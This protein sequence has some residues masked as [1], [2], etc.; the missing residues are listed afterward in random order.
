MKRRRVVVLSVLVAVLGVT[1]TGFAALGWD[2]DELG[3][4]R[5]G[6]PPALAPGELRVVNLN[7]FRLGQ[8]ERVP[9]LL[10]ALR[11]TGASLAHAEQDLPELIAIEE[12]ESEAAAQALERALAPSHEVITCV[13]AQRGDGS[14]RSAVA[15]GVARTLGVS[16]RRCVD[17]GRVWPDHTRCAAG[18][19]LTTREGTHEVSAFAVHLAWHVDNSSMAARLAGHLHDASARGRAIIL[20]G[21]LNTWPGSESYRTLTA[22][23]LRDAVPS[24]PPTHFTGGRLDYV[25]A[26]EALEVVRTLDRRATYERLRP[27]ETVWLPGDC[28]QAAR[29]R[30]RCPV[31]DHLPEG[32]VVRLRP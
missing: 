23:P 7:A 28:G 5:E 22:P 8:P 1:G 19:E 32:I 24:G 20:A 26:S 10:D 30:G 2:P 4:R 9:R 21:D 14:M 31:S 27:A 13:C 6:A 25:I 16:A 18:A 3:E 12:I 11:F 15:L 17:L 29:E